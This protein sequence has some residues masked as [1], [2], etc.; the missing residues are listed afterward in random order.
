MHLKRLLNTSLGKFFISVLLGLGLATLFRKVCTDK[1][2]LIFN[3]PLIDT[4]E[5]KIYKHGTKC[6]KY[7]ARSTK[8]DKHKKIID[9]SIHETPE[10]NTGNSYN[11]LIQASGSQQTTGT[12]QLPMKK[13]LLE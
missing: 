12:Q 8:C 13:G 10:K 5:G 6:F 4:V 3:G 9:M 1:N 7:T 11:P 2:C